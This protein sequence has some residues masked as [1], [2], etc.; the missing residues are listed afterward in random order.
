MIGIKNFDNIA[1]CF[2]LAV[3][4]NVYVHVSS[5]LHAGHWSSYSVFIC[6]LARWSH[7][8]Y[9][10]G[11]RRAYFAVESQLCWSKTDGDFWQCQPGARVKQKLHQRRTRFLYEAEPVHERMPNSHWTHVRR[12]PTVHTLI[13]DTDA[14]LARTQNLIFR[15]LGTKKPLLGLIDSGLP[16]PNALRPWTD[17]FRS[18][19]GL[20]QCEVCFSPS[21]CGLIIIMIVLFYVTCYLHCTGDA[22]DG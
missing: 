5:W 12:Q 18:V 13:M 15:L 8:S 1:S 6:D 16:I 21:S 20:F 19:N 2:S 22:N 4:A 7:L 11:A 17:S 9:F 14:L 3:I 10:A